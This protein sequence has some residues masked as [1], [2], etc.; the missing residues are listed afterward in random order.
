MARIGRS[1]VARTPSSRHGVSDST[2][3]IYRRARNRNGTGQELQP[4]EVYVLLRKESLVFLALCTVA[5][6]QGRGGAQGSAFARLDFDGEV[7]IEVPRHWTYFDDNL[8]KHIETA[9]EATTR[10]AGLPRPSGE[11]VILVAGRAQTSSLGTS[12][13]LRLS[14]RRGP[15]LTQAQML[16]VAKMPK[17]ELA[18][19]LA[20]VLEETRRVM[21]GVDGVIAAKPIDLGAAP[22]DRRQPL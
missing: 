17:A 18:Q 13:T 5:M 15:G 14:M 9:T 19:L 22:L 8:N 21:I 11:N 2:E 4:E 1:C 3:V 6:C 20:P 12:A 16:E 7:F 10:M